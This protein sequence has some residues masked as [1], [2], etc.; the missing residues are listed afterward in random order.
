MVQSIDKIHGTTSLNAE[1][2]QIVSMMP[3][4]LIVEVLNYAEYLLQKNVAQAVNS[5]QGDL[6]TGRQRKSLV[7]CLKGTF[8]LPLPDDFNEPLEDFAEYM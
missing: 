8:V 6:E 7:G 2:L 1:L 5:N 3:E 4:S